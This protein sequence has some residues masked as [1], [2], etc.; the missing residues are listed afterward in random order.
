METN[1]TMW[2]TTDRD[3]FNSADEAKFFLLKGQAK[4][5]PK[6]LTPILADAINQGLI[7]EATEEEIKTQTEADAYEARVREG[8]AKPVYGRTL[9]ETLKLRETKNAIPN[10]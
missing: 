7:R 10:N 4:Q 8:K 3:F 5:L 6:E 9:E 1:N 2:V